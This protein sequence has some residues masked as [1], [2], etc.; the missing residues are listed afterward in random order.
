MDCKP[1]VTGAVVVPPLVL[2]LAVLAVPQG[3]DN[4]AELARARVPQPAYYL[5]RPDGY[6]GCCGTG[7]VDPAALAAWLRDVTGP[8]A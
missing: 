1:P 7:A 4:D 2:L 3:A 5:L 8:G 6:V